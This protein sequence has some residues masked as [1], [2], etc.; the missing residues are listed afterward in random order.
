MILLV[1]LFLALP[2]YAE[3]SS[4][5]LETFLRAKMHRERIPA[6]QVSV[7]RHGKIVKTA[8]YGTANVENGV[9]ASKESIFSINA[10]EHLR[11]LHGGR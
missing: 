9:S 10:A 8:A 1:S 3:P 5:D 7:I 4:N 2:V 11:K 6:L